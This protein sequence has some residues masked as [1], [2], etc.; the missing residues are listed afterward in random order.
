MCLASSSPVPP[1]EVGLGKALCTPGLTG[2]ASSACGLPALLS[3]P[4]AELWDPYQ[5]DLRSCASPGLPGALSL[6]AS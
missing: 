1:Q 3:L 2:V 5:T 4:R 6:Q